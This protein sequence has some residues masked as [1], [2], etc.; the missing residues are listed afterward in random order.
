MSIDIGDLAPDFTLKNQH[1]ELVTLSSYRGEKNVVILFYPFSFTGICTGELCGIRDALE[2]FQNDAV[3][4]LAVSCD[5][6]FTQRVFAERENYQFPVLS[7]FWPHGSVAQAYGIFDAD[8]GCAIRG[9][10]IIDKEG[11]LRWKIVNAI[12]DARNLSEYTAA[13]ATL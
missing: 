13:L 8:R 6:P 11:V 7:D 9:T 2:L 5:T 4:V 3:Q 1:G 12:G 10:F